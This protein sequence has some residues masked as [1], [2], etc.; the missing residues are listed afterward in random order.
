MPNR[1]S[2]PT[3][4]AAEAY[5]RNR[6]EIDRLLERINEGILEA[7][8]SFDDADRKARER[9]PKHGA[10]RYVGNVGAVRET[11]QTLC[12]QVWQEGEYAPENKA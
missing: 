4:T 6:A 9:H 7:D 2:R 5:C 1:D 11:L 3:E 10:W 12:D 8:E